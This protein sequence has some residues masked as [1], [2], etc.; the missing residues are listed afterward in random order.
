MGW[1]E[2]PDPLFLDAAAAGERL[3]AR[4]RLVAVGVIAALQLAPGGDRRADQATIAL[5]LVALAVAAA[6][7]GLLTRR[8][9]PWIAF[10]SSACD[11][12]FVTLGLLSL[13]LVGKPHAAV[14]S[15][16]I[17]EIYFL[18]VG[19]SAL[20]YD[21]RVC[22]FTGALACLEYG[23][24]LLYVTQRWGL[25]NP[26]FG[27]YG[28]ALFSPYSQAARLAVLALATALATLSVERAREL[29]RL[30]A[31]DRLTGLHNRGAFGDRLEEESS[32]ARRHHRTFTVALVD[33]DAF[34]AFN[35]VHGHAGGDAALR[36]VAETCRRTLRRS[37]VVARYGGDEFGLILPETAAEEAVRR[38]EDLRRA[39]ASTLV[40]T[41]GAGGRLTVSIG[42]AS[43]PADGVTASDVTTKADARL[44]QAKHEGRDRVVGPREVDGADVLPAGG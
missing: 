20:R 37:D 2:P 42:V 33:V 26:D 43:W 34:K 11:V 8:Y 41:E 21:R 14:N 12:T 7:Y 15:L 24:L 1:R 31:I 36:T 28:D 3:V 35:D 38:M 10:A 6:V 30:S 16:S 39:V 5:L 32:R 4:I 44:Y 18:V 17:F 40:L 19:C 9:E 23:G 13:A 25:T 29:R 22:V 27:P